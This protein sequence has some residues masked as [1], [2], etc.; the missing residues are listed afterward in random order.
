MRSIQPDVRPLDDVREECEVRVGLLTELPG[1]GVG[2]LQP[3]F[4]EPLAQPRV[5]EGVF[6]GLRQ[7]FDDVGRRILGGEEAE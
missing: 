5:G 3:L 7:G 1:P 4:F 6:H 2:G